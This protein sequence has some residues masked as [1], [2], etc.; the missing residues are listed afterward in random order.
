MNAKKKLALFCGLLVIVAGGVFFSRTIA[1]VA[2]SLINI[3]APGRSYA[4]VYLYIGYVLACI[5]IACVWSKKNRVQHNVRAS[6]LLLWGFIGGLALNCMSFFWYIVRTGH[7]WDEYIVLFANNEISSTE[8]THNHVFKGSIGIVF[9]LIRGGAFTTLDPGVAYV[10]QLPTFFFALGLAWFVVMVASTLYCFYTNFPSVDFGVKKFLLYVALYTATTFVLLR[11]L[12]DGGLFDFATL[13]A[14]VFLTLLLTSYRN[15]KGL[16]AVASLSM[17]AVV[18]HYA[19]YNISGLQSYVYRSLAVTLLFSTLYFFLINTLVVQHQKRLRVLVGILFFAVCIGALN[20]GFGMLQYRHTAITPEGAVIA[21][22]NDLSNNSRF[23]QTGSIGD[24][25]FYM[26]AYATTS[27][28]TVGGLV[29]V[30]GFLDNHEPVTLP[31]VKCM[32]IDGAYRQSFIVTMRAPWTPTD[33][34]LV[35]VVEHIPLE[36]TDDRYR[37]AVTLSMNPCLPLPQNIVQQ[38]MKTQGIEEFAVT[39]ITTQK[40]DLIAR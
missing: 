40:Y 11:N 25:R 2:Q 29:D 17:L 6:A 23:T 22:H 32:P 19:P 30:S 26:F 1:D 38:F 20:R 16:I 15:R 21:T 14:L 31:W 12:L 37:Y 4:K 5:A 13:P 18:L 34:E 36:N 28:A 24:L 27:P 8:F 35:Q 39:R 10:G 3:F 33:H 9:Q 7:S